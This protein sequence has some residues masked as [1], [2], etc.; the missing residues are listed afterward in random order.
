MWPIQYLI[1]LHSTM[2][3]IKLHLE[4]SRLSSA[5]ELH[6]IDELLQIDESSDAIDD[7]SSDVVDEEPS[8]DDDDGSSDVV[9]G[10]SS[11]VN[12]PSNTDGSFDIDVLEVALANSPH[13]V[14]I[15]IVI[16]II[17]RVE[18]PFGLT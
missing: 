1:Y 12:K 11:N 18:L 16:T 13:V 14:I 6:G 15:I 2:M 3:L 10:E 5:N 17:V 4:I 8:D 9:N 7:E